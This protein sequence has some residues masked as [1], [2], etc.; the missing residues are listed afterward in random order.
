MKPKILLF[1]N[2]TAPAKGYFFGKTY[3]TSIIEVERPEFLFS[4]AWKWLGEKKIHCL[5]LPDFKGYKKDPYNDFKLIKAFAEVAKEAD[6]LVAHNGDNFD[7]TV[8]NTRLAVHGLTPLPPNKTVDTLKV[9]RSKFHLHSNKL[10]DACAFFG[11]GRKLPNTGKNLWLGCYFQN[12]Q[13]WIKMVRYNK[14]DVLL[15]EQLYLVLRPYITRHPNLNLLAGSL[16]NCPVCGNGRLQSRGTT[17]TRT[18][19]YRR[20]QCQDCGA[21]SQGEA[22]KSQGV[23]IR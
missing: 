7:I 9:L 22:I 21:W 6:I 3:E 8:L 5:S 2:E 16:K 11:I 1:D 15:L 13:S 12:P 18:A 4:I 17:I 14:H 10:D 19:K 23:V 20:Y